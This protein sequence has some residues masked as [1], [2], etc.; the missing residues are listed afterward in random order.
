VN[1]RRRDQRPD[2]LTAV[3]QVNQALVKVPT[4][5][6]QR[7]D[8]LVADLVR[9]RSGGKGALK[10]RGLSSNAQWGGE[11]DPAAGTVGCPA[12]TPTA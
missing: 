4:E 5:K 1:Q 9:V 7:V 6:L 11:I 2:Q 8:T 3:G 10:V 12:L